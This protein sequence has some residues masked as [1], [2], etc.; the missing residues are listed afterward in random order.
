M[1][2][3]SPIPP[4]GPYPHDLLWGQAGIIPKSAKTKIMSIIVPSDMTDSFKWCVVY[5]QYN[6]FFNRASTKQKTIKETIKSLFEIGIII[7][8]KG[9]TE[10]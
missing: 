5:D 4:L 2:K 3:I 1:I 10:G 6:V 8:T 9:M 7:M